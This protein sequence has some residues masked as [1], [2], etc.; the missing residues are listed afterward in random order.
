MLM[1]KIS[2]IEV[3]K[4]IPLLVP[5]IWLVIFYVFSYTHTNSLSRLVLIGM[6]FIFL[7]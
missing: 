3:E 5:V 1:V 7:K 6:F 4:V 2:N